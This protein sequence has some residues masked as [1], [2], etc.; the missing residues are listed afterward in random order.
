MYTV[1]AGRGATG[2]EVG[3]E[4]DG[5]EEPR[6]GN[7]EGECFGMFAPRVCALAA[8][9]FASTPSK[10]IQ[11]AGFAKLEKTENRYQTAARVFALHKRACLAHGCFLHPHH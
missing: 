6:K 2:G 11:S 5:G 1:S 4:R 9:H 8:V 3:G 10:I 7:G